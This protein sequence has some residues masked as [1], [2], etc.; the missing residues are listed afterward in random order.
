MS[1]SILFYF[2]K[3][4]T[5]Q[6][7]FSHFEEL[8]HKTTVFPSAASLRILWNAIVNVV[9]NSGSTHDCGRLDFWRIK[10]DLIHQITEKWTS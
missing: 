2:K 8:A 5:K 3:T 10:C 7:L 9:E 6:I 4:Q 1:K